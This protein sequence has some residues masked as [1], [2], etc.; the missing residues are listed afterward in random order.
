MQDTVATVALQICAHLPSPHVR[1]A[2]VWI[3][4][5]LPDH[6]VRDR[7]AEY[8]LPEEVLMN[9]GRDGVRERAVVEE[10]A[11]HGLTDNVERDV[12]IYEILMV[13]LNTVGRHGQ[14]KR[15]GRTN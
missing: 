8:W 4:W 15:V 6:N 11:S 9:T 1:T 14:P 7:V 3:S 10:V 2:E 12:P 5:R 13:S